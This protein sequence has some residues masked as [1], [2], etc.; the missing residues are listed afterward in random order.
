M[1]LLGSR[2][3]AL[4]VRRQLD[5]VGRFF[6][7]RLSARTGYIV[8]ATPDLI[9]RAGFY[10]IHAVAPGVQVQGALRLTDVAQREGQLLNCA[11]F[12]LSRDSSF[13]AEAVRSLATLVK[14]R[15]RRR[16]RLSCAGTWATS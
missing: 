10:P 12:L 4:D 3:S 11:F 9:A 1:E 5:L 2:Q 6:A 14:A 13:T 7:E 15:R 16:S 8:P